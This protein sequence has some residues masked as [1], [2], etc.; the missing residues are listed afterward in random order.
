M[1]KIHFYKMTGTGNDFIVIDNRK[2]VIDS[3]HCLDFIRSVCRPKVSVGADGVILIESDPEVDF[4]WRFFNAD[5]SEP[6]MC[7]NGARCAARFAFLTGIADKPRMAFRTGAGIVGAELLDT[8]VKVRM[9]APHSLERNL[10]VMARKRPFDLDFINSGVPH[11]VCFLQDAQELEAI[12][13]PRWGSALRN[14]T[15]FKPEGT[16]VD[17]VYVE[18]PQNLWVRT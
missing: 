14:H 7:G 12:D 9:P 13:V 3:D 1:Q 15:R 18:N 10:A 4:R 16:N 6:D 2:R 8:K 5:G 11:A 17:F